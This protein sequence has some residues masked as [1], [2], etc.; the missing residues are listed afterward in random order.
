MRLMAQLHVFAL[1]AEGYV[2]DQC[3]LVRHAASRRADRGSIT[4][5]QVIW[6]VAI[7]A[8][9]GIVVTAITS[10]VTAQAGKIK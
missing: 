7:I 2:T 5:E 6:A 3:R 1:R 8:I 9:V 4:I 10:Y